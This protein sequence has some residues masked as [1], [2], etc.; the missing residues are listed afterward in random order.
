MAHSDIPGSSVVLKNY[1]ILYVDDEPSNLDVFVA[2]F[3]DEFEILTAASGLEAQAVLARQRISVLIADQRMPMITGIELCEQVRKDYPQVVRML[4]T[5]YSDHETV[6]AA[7]N[8]G[9]VCRYLTKP[10]DHDDVRQVL[11]EVVTRAHLESMVRRLGAAIVQGDRQASAA[12][13]RARLLHDLAS[14]LSVVSYCSGSV[15]SLMPR[16]E[17]ELSPEL[18]SDLQE[19]LEAMLSASH[20]ATELYRGSRSTAAALAAGRAENRVCDLITTVRHLVQAGRNSGAR[21]DVECPDSATAWCNAGDV[22]RIL[23]NLINNAWEAMLSSGAHEGT[24]QLV[25]REQDER[26]QLLVSDDGP[27]IP[28]D[29][30]PN[31]FQPYVTSKGD[32]GGSGLG[33]TICQELARA[34]DGDLQLLDADHPLAAGRKT[35]FSLT[36][37]RFAGK[38][39]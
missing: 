37:P 25:I 36:L 22:G 4:M 2:Q 3:G 13:G 1:S 31:M 18:W 28:V 9:G 14:P 6:I 21:L 26:T 15:R 5:A 7:I 39:S 32:S 20:Q 27:G 34:N 11:R 19:D 33:L 10:W 35:T 38:G 24:V 29:I 12:A 16:L 23:V 30:I 8:R 17:A